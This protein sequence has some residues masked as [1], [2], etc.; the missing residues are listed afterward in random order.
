MA[1]LKIL[2]FFLM[3]LAYGQVHEWGFF[4]GGINYVGD[5]GD[6]R[7]Y[8]PDGFSG[9]V[10]YRSNINEWYSVRL[11]L[12][13]GQLTAS[14][15]FAQSLGR[16]MR[17]WQTSMNIMDFSALFEYNFL[18]L[19]PYKRPLKIL[20]TPYLATGISVFR[21]ISV[22]RDNFTGNALTN[23]ENSLSIP[24]NFG[25]KFSLS[26]HVKF[27]WEVSVRYCMTDDLEGSRMFDS[28]LDPKTDRLGNDWYITSGI[29]LT[30]G[31]GE[32]PCYLNVF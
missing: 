7:F 3:P 22:I 15:R 14:D 24:V 27:N 20:T 10:Y 29:G 21:S 8:V 30:F 12:G 4:A 1:K 32:L 17:N 28:A 2:F 9:S 6:D 18:P 23:Y 5:I 13:Y 26:R 31:F 19:N 16:R 25:I 11:E